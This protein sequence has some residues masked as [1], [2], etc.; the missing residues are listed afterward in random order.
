VVEVEGHRMVLASK[1]KYPPIRMAMGEYENG[2]T[3]LF[4]DHIKPGMS[5]LDIGAHAGYYTLLAAR[6]TDSGARVFSFLDEL[7]EIISILQGKM[8]FVGPRLLDLTEY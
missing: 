1:G 7:P 4:Q 2:T 5:I 3:Q 8:S 6:L